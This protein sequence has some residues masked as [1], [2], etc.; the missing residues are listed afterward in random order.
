MA[1]KIAASVLLSAP[2]WLLGNMSMAAQ[3]AAGMAEPRQMGFQP[4]A[5]ETMEK[6]SSFHDLLMIIMTLIVILVTAL[7][8]VIVIRFNRKANPVPSKTSHNTVL[9]IVWTLIPIAILIGIA[10]PSFKLLYFQDVAPPADMVIKATGHQWYWTYEYPD[11]GDLTFDASMLPDSYYAAEMSPAVREDRAA[12]LA[13]IQHLLGRDEAPEIHRLLDTDSRVV[14]PVGKVV[15]VL[16]TADDVIHA[17][18]IPAF[19]IKIDTVPGRM[20]ETWFKA[21]RIGTFYGQCS[22]LCGIRHAFM[23][24]VV[25]VV[26]EEDFAAWLGRARAMYNTAAVVQPVRLASQANAQ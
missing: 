11:H 19:G 3:A 24:I 7:L 13:D 8:L 10:F 5:T 2:A 26:S 22:E 17:W 20:N 14:V 9:E 23:P 18:A 25:E 21:D 16:V 12:A 4:A 6:I 1:L 15:K